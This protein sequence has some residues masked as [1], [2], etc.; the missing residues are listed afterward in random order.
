MLVDGR[1]APIFGKDEYPPANTSFMT[2]IFGADSEDGK[3][4]C[5][6]I[7][8]DAKRCRSR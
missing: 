4:S 6:V 8:P 1:E 5:V 7:A 3:R 2:S